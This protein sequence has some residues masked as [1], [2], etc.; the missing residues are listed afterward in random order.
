M[1]LAAAR[2][3]LTLLGAIAAS[4][5]AVSALLGLLAGSSVLRAVSLGFYVVGALIL[6]TG[7][8]FGNRGPARL[9]PEEG[10]GGISPLGYLGS[11]RLRWAT[12]EEQGEAINMSAVLVSLGFALI[13]LGAVADT[14]YKFL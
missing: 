8:F 5:A 14:R 11:R 13:I 4:T 9:R 3:F 6:L 12:R 10:G 1:L 2:R 7:F